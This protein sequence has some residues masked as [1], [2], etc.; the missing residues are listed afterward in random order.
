MYLDEDSQQ[1]PSK[2]QQ[3]LVRATALLWVLPV[4][5]HRLADVEA[6]MQLDVQVE[7]WASVL[8]QPSQLES[9]Y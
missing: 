8:V 4:A 9:H 6:S 7:P 3:G 5:F 1:Q 2:M